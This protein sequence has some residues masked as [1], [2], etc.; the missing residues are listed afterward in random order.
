MRPQQDGDSWVCPACGDRHEG[1]LTFFAQPAPEL[2]A[3]APLWARIRAGRSRSFRSFK[4][5]GKRRYF[6][7]GHLMIPRLEQPDDPFGWSV[8]AEVDETDFRLL[9]DTLEDPQRVEQAPIRGHLDADLPYEDPTRG[10]SVLLHQNPPGEVSDITVSEAEHHPLA[11]EQRNGI[12]ETR[13]A[14]I[15]HSLLSGAQG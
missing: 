10:L 6:V 2:W 12:T 4:T 13:V 8:W 9:V 5:T 11:I 14:E 7:R 15:K 1:P 3:T